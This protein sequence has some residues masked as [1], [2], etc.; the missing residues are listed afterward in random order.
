MEKRRELPAV[1]RLTDAGR[2]AHRALDDE[3]REAGGSLVPIR[4]R[5][6]VRV[7]GPTILDDVTADMAVGREEI[8]GPV[9]SVVRAP[10]YDAAV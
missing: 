5:E 6:R 2:A 8:F 9:L 4:Y 1:E 3:V 7:S 10:S